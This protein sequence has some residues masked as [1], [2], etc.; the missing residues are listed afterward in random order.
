MTK[1]SKSVLS[2]EF[3]E[4]KNHRTSLRQSLRSGVNEWMDSIR[5][6]NSQSTRLNSR[7]FNFDHS[8][9]RKAQ[10]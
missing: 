9:E 2:I 4:G 7:E 10:G 8:V 3:F 5:I 1:K 6:A